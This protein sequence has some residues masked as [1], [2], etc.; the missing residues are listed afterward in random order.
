[1][2][3]FLREPPENR[4]K[5][6]DLAHME[7]AHPNRLNMKLLSDLREQDMCDV[8][9]YKFNQF[10]RD[11]DTQG[12]Y[13]AKII[14]AVYCGFPL[15]SLPFS[16]TPILMNDYKN[17]LFTTCLYQFVPKASCLNYG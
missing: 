17:K 6:E 5:I 13:G 14:I 15:T 10:Q 1:M 7:C 4:K 8:G 16:V 12:C 2:V 9:M 11:W 3:W